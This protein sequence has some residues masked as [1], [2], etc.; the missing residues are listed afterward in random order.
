MSIIKLTNVS[1]SYGDIN[2]LKNITFDINEGDKIGIIGKNG[3]GKSTLINII[4]GNT[5]A[6]NGKVTTCKN[7][8]IGYNICGVN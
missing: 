7:I 5:K 4:S 1:K 8:K 3:A 6:D 2:T